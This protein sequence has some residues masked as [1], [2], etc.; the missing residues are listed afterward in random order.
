MTLAW[1]DEMLNSIDFFCWICCM[2][3]PGIIFAQKILL[4]AAILLC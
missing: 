2:L 4:G 1:Q 3:D